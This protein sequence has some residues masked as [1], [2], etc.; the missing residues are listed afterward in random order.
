MKTEVLSS[1]LSGATMDLELLCKTA[2]TLCTQINKA[3]KEKGLQHSQWVLDYEDELN[4][5]SVEF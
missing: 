4:K 5:L 2:L 3:I 1:S